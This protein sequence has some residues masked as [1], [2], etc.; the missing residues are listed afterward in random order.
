MV[1]QIDDQI[2]SRLPFS[3]YFWNREYTPALAAAVS[4][5]KYINRQRIEVTN[6]YSTTMPDLNTMMICPL[7]F[8]C[9]SHSTV[10]LSSPGM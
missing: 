1:T 9:A 8:N 2:I 3:A 5:L 6:D 10:K 4:K 7:L